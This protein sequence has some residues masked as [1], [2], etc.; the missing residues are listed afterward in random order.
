MLSHRHLNQ[1]SGY[2]ATLMRDLV[3]HVECGGAMHVELGFA[4]AKLH[5]ER[6]RLSVLTADQLQE[7]T[8]DWESAGIV[9]SQAMWAAL[10]HVKQTGQYEDAAAL[11]SRRVQRLLH[12]RLWR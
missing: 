10:G 7:L 6:E 12:P 2:A 1:L 4:L 9:M 8:M 3:R 11:F 5:E